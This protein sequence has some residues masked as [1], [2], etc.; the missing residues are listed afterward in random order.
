MSKHV[1][2]VCIFCFI[3]ATHSPCASHV[4]VGTE[5]HKQFHGLLKD[6]NGQQQLLEVNVVRGKS[7][8]DTKK[9]SESAFRTDQM[10]HIVNKRNVN[11][12]DYLKKIF[13]LYGDGEHMGIE[14]FEKLMKNLLRIVSIK[15]DKVEEVVGTSYGNNSKQMVSYQKAKR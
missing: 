2:S 8:D 14:G 15:S 11:D 7:K 13:T 6:S 10:H 3:C 1:I 9:I 5:Q 12:A 4:A